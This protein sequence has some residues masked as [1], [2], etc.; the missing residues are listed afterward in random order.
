LFFKSK[1][2]YN[3]IINAGK[4]QGKMP[5]LTGAKPVPGERPHNVNLKIIGRNIDQAAKELGLGGTTDPGDRIDAYARRVESIMNG[6]KDPLK[7]PL[8][9]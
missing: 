1:K 4:E 3:G 7:S 5:K 8:D 2:P 9:E 6:G